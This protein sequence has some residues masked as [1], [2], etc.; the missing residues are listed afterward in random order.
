MFRRV[1]F[2]FTATPSSSFLRR[3]I[4]P[5]DA[6]I[7]TML[8]TIGQ[9]SM[10]AF[11]ESVVPASIRNNVK[12]GFEAKTET[13]ALQS[14]ESTMA[15]NQVVKS[16]IGLGFYENI[17]PSVV[18]R[19]VLES[20][21]WYTPY[22][23]YQ[24]EI[25]QG[26]LESLLNFQT[27]I[28][29]LTRMQVC[30]ASLLDE[31]TAAGEAVTMCSLTHARAKERNVFYV[32]AECHPRTIEL[33]KTRAS[34]HDIQIEVVPTQSIVELGEKLKLATGVLL[35]YPDTFG[36]VAENIQSII[37][38]VKQNG[39]TVV[40]ASDLLALTLLKPPGELGADIVIGSAQRFGVPM[41]YGG[42]SAAFLATTDE[43][44]RN[45][46]GRIIGVSKDIRNKRAIRMALQ[47][48][49]QHIRRERATS[50]ICTAQALLANIS[51]FYG[52]Y[53]GPDGLKDIASRVKGLADKFYNVAA[54][55]GLT[56]SPWFFDTVKLTFPEVKQSIKFQN[57]AL[58]KGINIRRVGSVCSVAFDEATT[59]E[60]LQNLCTALRKTIRAKKVVFAPPVLPQSLQRTSAFMQQSVFNKYHSETGMMRYIYSLQRKDLGLNVAMIPL[61]SCTMKL[62]AA[63]E[64]IPL[65]WKTISS[66]HPFCPTSQAKGYHEMMSEL[67][68]RLATLMGFD[69]VCLQP[70][71]G[72][73][74]EYAGLR[75][76]QAY[77]ASRNDTARDKCLI[78]QSAHGT[79]PASAT[80]AGMKVVVIKCKENGRTDLDH[81]KQ[82]LAEIGKEVSCLMITYPST[83]GI[84][85][86][87]V[88]T[89]CEL[90][91]QAGGQ[92][93]I[94]GANLNA[95]VGLTSPG[96][97]GG[98]VAHTNLHKTFSIPHG[99]GG[100][101]M[102]PIGV[103]KHLIP[104]LPGN[105]KSVG[106][107]SQA[108]FGSASILTISSMYITMMGS[109]G[110]TQ[111]TQMAILNA[112]YLM[113]RLKA[114]YHILY[115]GNN[116]T[117]AHEFIID[118]RPLKAF[119]EAE[120][121]AKRLM[122]YNFHA[123]TLSFPVA[124]TLMVEPTESEPLSEL[125]R[126]ADAMISIREE[127]REIEQGK[128]PK[129]N[130]LL[131]NA[132][133]VQDVVCEETWNRPY[134]RERAVFPTAE[135][136][137]N[138][139]WPTVSR[140]DG[141]HGDRVFN[142]MC[143]S[144]LTEAAAATPATPKA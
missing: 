38:T 17:M 105:K 9:P 136:R 137:A 93:Y 45:M 77:H 109:S 118:L 11:I 92:V 125:D 50:N 47:T 1:T 97:I 25:A 78:L 103:K 102:G 135:V 63:S 73:Q 7:P 10:S 143:E 84:F 70:N 139:F 2:R 33:V 58:K 39:S 90:V 75:V 53:H 37:Q 138:K 29:E 142:C 64:M 122:D 46:P 86:D 120:D 60:H 21:G 3:H 91:H 85:E 28:I 134:S 16:C 107:I 116:N 65:T 69:D 30:N 66:M 112:N 68:E 119:V 110:L 13:E 132:P 94:D 12:Q 62:N 41:G 121:V 6:E 51:A 99:G 26:R 23:P 52:I 5:T 98:D 67:K 123:P 19:N 56:S 80:M 117:C 89:V 43:L 8:K 81:L 32:A 131:H 101:G 34:P 4:G 96:H 111:A 71:S 127:I 100:P 113:A 14:L 126:F 74:G 83:Y 36:S 42:P 27:M 88:K 35:Q 129:D 79:N 15:Q 49:E 133:H 76:I 18:Q 87:E 128:V 141:A 59:E 22:T 57:N 108:P 106:A 48:R 24:A 144:P 140:I 55:L 95:L 61:G 82:V 40:V 130:N 124:G 20:P 31:A 44:K 54:S 115:T 72:A 104:F 114:H